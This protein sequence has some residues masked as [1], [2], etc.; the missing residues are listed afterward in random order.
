MGNSRYGHHIVTSLKTPPKFTPE[1]NAIYATWVA[2]ILYMDQNVVDGASQ[3]NCSWYRE[4][5]PPIGR[6]FEEDWNALSPSFLQI[7]YRS[8]Y[9]RCHQVSPW[10]HLAASSSP[11][12]A[13]ISASHKES[14]LPDT[15]RFS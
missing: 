11:F 10:L 4:P 6:C 14:S 5:A 3:M 15:D 8:F 2:R 9:W 7:H 12:P 13:M 1:F